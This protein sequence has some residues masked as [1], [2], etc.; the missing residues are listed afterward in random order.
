MGKDG[1]EIAKENE[2]RVLRALHRFGWLR[3]RDLASL[4][5]Q[6][7][8]KNPVGAPTMQ[9]PVATASGLRMAQRTLRRLLNTRQVLSSQAPDGSLVYALSEAG[10]RSLERLGVPTAA[11][12]KDLVRRFSAAQF[13]HRTIANQIAI[14]G[15]LAGF[16]VSSEREIAQDRWLG[17]AKGIEGKKPDVLLQSNGCAWWIEVERSRRSAKDYTKLLEW[18]RIVGHDAFRQSGSILLGSGL[19]WERIIFICTPSFCLKLINY[20]KSAG[21]KDN[22]INRLLSFESS[23]YSFK[24]IL[25]E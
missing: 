5:W 10:A 9:P 17:G 22:A 15:I 25:F 19:R 16:R 18:L 7:R 4:L 21:W 11:S 1:R 12:G 8:G 6:P 13:R 2:A 23:L 24:D 3:T 14:V 20:L